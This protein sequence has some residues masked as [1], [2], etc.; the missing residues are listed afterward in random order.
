M[1]NR[2]ENVG[3]MV[4]KAKQLLTLYANVANWRKRSIILDMFGWEKL[5]INNCARN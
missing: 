3:Y 4:T 5:S 2:I 1:H